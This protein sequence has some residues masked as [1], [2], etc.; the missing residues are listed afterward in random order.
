MT[1]KTFASVIGVS[2]KTVEAWETGTNKPMKTAC[3]L[4]SMI[5][6]D[7]QILAKCKIVN[8]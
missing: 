5:N 6:T 8:R 4:I 3:R 7:P 2:T 1:Q